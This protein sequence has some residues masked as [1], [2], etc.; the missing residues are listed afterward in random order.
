MGGFFTSFFLYISI[1]LQRCSLDRTALLAFRE[2]CS[3]L[4]IR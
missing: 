4:W 3:D 2:E 1:S